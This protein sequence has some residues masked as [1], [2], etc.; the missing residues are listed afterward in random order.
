MRNSIS[1]FVQTMRVISTQNWNEI[2]KEIWQTPGN[3]F[4]GPFHFAS[5]FENQ[6]SRN[7]QR[8]NETALTV[9]KLSNSPI[10]EF[11]EHVHGH[12]INGFDKL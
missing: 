3:I 11:K 9:A 12:M 6:T 1:N 8:Q 4:S 2:N 10:A 5:P 7:L